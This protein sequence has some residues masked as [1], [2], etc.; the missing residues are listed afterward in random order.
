MY[1]RYQNKNEKFNV[2]DTRQSFLLKMHD[3]EARKDF[4]DK[5][6]KFREKSNNSSL[7]KE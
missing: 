1:A 2:F 5:V 3:D 4:L 6:N 7:K